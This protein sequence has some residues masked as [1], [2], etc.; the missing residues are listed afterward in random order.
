MASN[1]P[2][3]EKKPSSPIATSLLAVSS[4]ALV[5]AIVLLGMMLRQQT[6]KPESQT[7]PTESARVF[8]NER[9]DP[10]FKKADSV[11][12]GTPLETQPAE[13]EAG[14]ED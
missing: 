4:V 14:S 5:A 12:K 11:I 1:D 13:E 7:A 9:Y 6:Y 10:V 3:V 8:Y 2:I